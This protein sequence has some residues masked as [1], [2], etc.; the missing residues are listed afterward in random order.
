M[1]GKKNL[2]KKVAIIVG[3]LLAASSAFWQGGSCF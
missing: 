2:N 3:I 1:Y